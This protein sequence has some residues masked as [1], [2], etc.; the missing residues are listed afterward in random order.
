MKLQ[1]LFIPLDNGL[2]L[3]IVLVADD[4]VD[5]REIR[6][7]AVGRNR[8]GALGRRDVAKAR[9]EDALVVLTLDKRVR[10]VAV[11]LDGREHDDTVLV[12][13]LVRLLDRH[14]AALHRHVVDRAT[15][16]DLKRNVLD[17]VAVLGGKR[18]HLCRRG[19]A[20]VQRRLQHKKDL[21]CAVGRV[22]ARVCGGA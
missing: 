11:G 4:V 13:E 5:E 18:R 19:A 9:Q 10:A 7:L 1:H 8:V 3:M 14:G 15:V 17:S 22:F 21:F 2:H 12:L 6:R 20:W 16:V